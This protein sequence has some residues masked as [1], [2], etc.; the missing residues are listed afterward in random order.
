MEVQGRECEEVKIGDHTYY[1]LKEFK[2]KE[3][4][5]IQNIVFGEIGGKKVKLNAGVFI[6][7]IPELFEVLCMKIDDGSVKVDTRFLDNLTIEDYTKVPSKVV[8]VLTIFFSQ[9]K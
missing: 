9:I 7:N 8:E 2:G 5:L 3:Y 1:F 6:A 4:R